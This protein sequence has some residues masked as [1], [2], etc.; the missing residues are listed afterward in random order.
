MDGETTVFAGSHYEKVGTS[1]TKY[2]GCNSQTVRTNVL[3]AGF[4]T[5]NCRDFA[6]WSTLADVVRTISPLSLVNQR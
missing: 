6:L 1:V 2:Y 3:V 5:G 4:H